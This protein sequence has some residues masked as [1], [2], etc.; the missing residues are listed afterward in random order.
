M[1]VAIFCGGIGARLAELT[2]RVPKGLIPV[3]ER[4]ILW[5][6]MKYFA[7]FGHTSFV[8]LVGY[9]AEQFV[10]YFERYGEPG[11]TL[12]FE[13]SGA[14]ATKSER[15]LA[16]QGR[17]NGEPF[18]MAY[19]DDLSD[20]DLDAV[21]ERNERTG[22]VVTLT[23]VRPANP[24][25]IVCVTGDGRVD[26]FAEKIP[27]KDWI[28]GGYMVARPAIFEYLSKGELESEVFPALAA[29][30]LI[31]AHRHQGFWMSMNTLKESQELTRVWRS[32]NVPWLRWKD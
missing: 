25:G 29:A 12:E 21:R 30:G 28:N 13:D 7:S 19:G 2:E 20:V 9:K 26:H 18:F 8:L 5:H 27:L 32:G 1:K 31:D 23:A 3:G 17:L 11:W 14:N 24:F 6:I 15:L 4:P 22:A 16:A 10:A